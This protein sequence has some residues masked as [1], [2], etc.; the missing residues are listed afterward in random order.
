[1]ANAISVEQL[2]NLGE[3]LLDFA[4]P[5]DLSTWLQNNCNQL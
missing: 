1:M 5:T 4:I 2:E 3:A